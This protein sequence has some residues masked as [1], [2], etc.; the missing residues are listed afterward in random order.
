MKIEKG[1]QSNCSEAVFRFYTLKPSEMQ[2]ILQAVANEVASR[3][4]VM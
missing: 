2:K 4:K 1:P 3:L